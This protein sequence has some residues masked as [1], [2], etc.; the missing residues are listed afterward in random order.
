MTTTGTAVAALA[1]TGT[2]GA[3]RTARVPRLP[4]PVRRALRRR[5]ERIVLLPSAL[6]TPAVPP[7]ATA[8]PLTGPTRST[9]STEPTSSAGPTGPVGSTGPAPRGVGR[10]RRPLAQ[11]HSVALPSLGRRWREREESQAAD[12]HQK[13]VFP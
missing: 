9:R 10:R 5:R 13:S 7:G 11:Q 12:G 3:G 2:G 1:A 6:V 4:R 8:L